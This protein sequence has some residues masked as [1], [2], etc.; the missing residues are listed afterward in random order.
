MGS[1]ENKIGRAAAVTVKRFL[2]RRYYCTI[3][4]LAIELAMIAKR[5]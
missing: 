4:N 2:R 3:H 5:L 1:T